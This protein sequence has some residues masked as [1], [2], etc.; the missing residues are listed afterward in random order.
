MIGL[1]SEKSESVIPHFNLTE[2]KLFCNGWF[3]TSFIDVTIKI[4]KP[5]Q[6]LLEGL[7]VNRHNPYFEAG[8]AKGRGTDY[9]RQ[10][11]SEK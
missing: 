1:C 2:I 8:G 6:P 11:C 7:V 10:R 3:V 5:S 9:D 4:S